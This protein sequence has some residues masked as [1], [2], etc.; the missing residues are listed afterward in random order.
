MSNA[1][2]PHKAVILMRMEVHEVLDTGECSG[3]LVGPKTLEK[4]GMKPK[5]V[6]TISGQT[7]E[8]CLKKLKEVLDG[9]E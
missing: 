3:K 2:A 6:V 4:Y 8:Q 9:F 5:Q 1:K 7:Q